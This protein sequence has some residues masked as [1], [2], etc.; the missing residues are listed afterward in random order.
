MFKVIEQFT[1]TMYDR[2]T[3][4]HE[5]ANDL[6]MDLSSHKVGYSS[7]EILRKHKLLFYHTCIAMP[8]KLASDS[9]IFLI[10]N[11]PKS[12]TFACWTKKENRW[13]D[14]IMDNITRCTI[15]LGLNICRQPIKLT[16]RLVTPLLFIRCNKPGLQSTALCQCGGKCV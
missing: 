8:T 3:L 4:Y 15:Q 6:R 13:I 7:W 2:N 11:I 14:V 9:E 1:S 5:S 10:R 16:T 12:D